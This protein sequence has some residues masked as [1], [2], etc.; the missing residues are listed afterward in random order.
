MHLLQHQPV[1]RTYI[2]ILRVSWENFSLLFP[3]LLTVKVRLNQL[4]AANWIQFTKKLTDLLTI[5]Y[6]NYTSLNSYIRVILQTQQFSEQL[7]WQVKGAW[8]I[9]LTNT[10]ALRHMS[11]VP[12]AYKNFAIFTKWNNL[13]STFTLN[14][15]CNTKKALNKFSI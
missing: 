8:D 10:W 11:H 1:T 12:N 6:K 5:L 7:N 9:C 13:G 4:F 3:Q 15:K 14:E 2:S